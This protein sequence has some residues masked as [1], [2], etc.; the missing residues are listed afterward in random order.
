M[1]DTVAAVDCGTNTAR[2]LISRDGH[3]VVRREVVTRLGAD[4]ERDGVLGVDALGRL[5]AA[6]TS[7]AA[8]LASHGVTTVRAVATSAARDAA[9]SDA[10]A[11]IVQR[12]VGVEPVILSGDDEAR[13]SFAGATAGIDAASAPF[14]VVD[15]G[16]GSTEFAVGAAGDLQVMSLDMGSVRFTERYI[17]SDPPAPEELLA[18]ISV[19]EAHLSD[20]IREIPAAGDAATFVAVAGTALTVAAVEIGC[21]PDDHEA[22]HGFVLVRAA[23]EDVFR[24]LVTEPLEDRLHNP[25]L[26][27][28]RAEV[29]VGGAALLVATMRA[30][31]IDELVVSV[32]DLLDGL[33]AE[34]TPGRAS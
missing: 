30:L 33:V 10:L 24:T 27:P 18:C 19:A 32:H 22:I 3:D 2:L 15:I 16:G 28:D 20:L 1:S 17:E 9:N 12:T 8:D 13:L 5:D 4:L 14:C 25:G 21:E 29:I 26:H 6:L 31:S 34:A 7:F 11:A 23:A